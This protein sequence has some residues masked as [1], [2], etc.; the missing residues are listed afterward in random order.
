MSGKEVRKLNCYEVITASIRWCLDIEGLTVKDLCAFLEHINF[1]SS[2]ARNDDFKDPTHVNYYKD[3]RKLAEVECFAAFTAK[4]TGLSIF[5]Y[6]S[7]NMYPKNLNPLPT[8]QASQ[9]VAKHI[10]IAGIETQVAPGLRTNV[11]SVTGTQSVG[12]KA[13][14]DIIILRIDVPISSFI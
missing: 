11:T 10:A 5:H 4:H 1:L 14:K 12:A 8:L 13:I 3:I 7:Q 6:G 9:K 2:H